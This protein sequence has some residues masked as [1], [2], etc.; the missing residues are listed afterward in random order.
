MTDKKSRFLVI[1]PQ[2]FFQPRGT[3]FSVY[4]RSL[5]TSEMGHDVDLL[6]YGEGQDVELPGLRIFRTPRF[7]MLGNVKI[8]PS[9]L[10]LFLDIFIFF[11]MFWLLLRNRYDVVHAHEE[12]VFFA[13]LL[14]PIFRYR[15][16]YDMHSSLPQQLENFNFSSSKI[17]FSIFEWLEVKALKH[18]D[19][20]I[21]ICPDLRDYVDK[22]IGKQDRH[23]LIENSIFEPVK[24][25]V[26]GKGS[27]N[28]NATDAISFISEIE[29]RNDA[30]KYLVY[31][32]TLEH[33]QGIG[34]LIKSMKHVIECNENVHLIVVGGDDKQVAEFRKLSEKLG[35]SDVITFTLRVPQAIAKRYIERADV[36]LSPRSTGTNTPLKIYEQLAS[37]KPLVATN[38]YSHT[39]VLSNDD[40]FLVEPEEHDM[41]KGI[42][43]ALGDKEVVEKKV[44]RALE[45]YETQYSR[46]AYTGKLTRLF[47]VVGL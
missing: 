47:K 28:D 22:T 35:L 34:T 31:A 13:V 20:I 37:G 10:K 43:L 4:Y 36:L 14:K 30:I 40:C 29:S 6:A 7:K 25:A 8:G 32:G 19:G 41:A 17:L 16:I 44:A 27:A 1:A 12:G 23:V 3:P 5:I 38:I 45:I 11:Q 46:L 21:T 42:N 33:Y 39:Q 18:A 2:P 9:A 26:V 15:L 24:L